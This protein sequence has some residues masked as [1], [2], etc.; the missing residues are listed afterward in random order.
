MQLSFWPYLFLFLAYWW[1]N[2]AGW[3]TWPH[4]QLRAWA[5]TCKL[6]K[7]S[8]MLEDWS[9]PTKLWKRSPWD[10][11]S[12]LSGKAKCRTCCH[13]IST[14]NSKSKRSSCVFV[15]MFVLIHLEFFW[16]FFYSAQY[17]FSL[18]AG[19]ERESQV[20][21][22][23]FH[24]RS[25]KTGTWCH[26]HRGKQLRWSCIGLKTWQDLADGSKMWAWR[27]ANR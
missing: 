19:W 3:L 7:S 12:L 2:R 5:T 13:G 15:F 8:K 25:A 21:S 14:W 18:C 6:M 11:K 10:A 16:S 9:K 1:I 26:R 4:L 22:I 24:S 17:K 27:L 23:S 20:E